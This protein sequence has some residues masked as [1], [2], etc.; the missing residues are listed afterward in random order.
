M[1]SRNMDLLNGSVFYSVP[2]G[3]DMCPLALEFYQLAYSV[4]QIVNRCWRQ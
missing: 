2:V 1:V 4:T 3:G